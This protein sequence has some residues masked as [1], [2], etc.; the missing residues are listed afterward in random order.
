MCAVWL[1][2]TCGLGQTGSVAPT[3]VPAGKTPAPPKA[4]P[5]PTDKQRIAALPEADRT[6]LQVFVAPIILPAEKKAFLELTQSYERDAFREQFWQRRERDGQ[7]PPRGP[8][9]RYRYADLR[10][11]ADSVYDHWP[12]DAA[13]MVIRYGEPADVRPVEGCGKT[14]LD[15]LEVWTYTHPSALGFHTRRYLFYRRSLGEPRRLWVF[16]TPE[17]DIFAPNSCRKTFPE[18]INDCTVPPMDK[19][20]GP[21][22]GDACDVFKVWVET[23]SRQGS[24]AGGQLETSHLLAPEEIS[25]EGL[26]SVKLHSP[27]WSDPQAARIGVEGPGG[28]AGSSTA[29]NAE[30]EPRHELSRLEILERIG[31]LEPKYRKFLDT[32]A[33]LMTEHE[34][35]EFLQ[36]SPA[37]KDRFIGD[38]WRRRS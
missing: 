17:K 2:F 5:T 10:Q 35:S 13:L 16:G 8:G 32:A 20:F 6:W 22:C 31:R 3:P 14:F 12:N 27:N 4:T 25:L 29:P 26:D 30:S 15:G 1:G 38:F 11:L 7:L 23:T 9:Y 36:L 33:P 18:M 24:A 37:E 34:L 19:C 28:T 21:V